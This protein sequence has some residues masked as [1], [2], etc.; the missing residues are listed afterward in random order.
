MAKYTHAYYNIIKRNISITDIRRE[1]LQNLTYSEQ[2]YRGHLFC[3]GCEIVPLAL[4][5]SNGLLYF[6]GYPNEKHRDGCL[7]SLDI[8]II[9]DVKKIDF[10]A[11][12]QADTQ[13]DAL[14]RLLSAP[15]I[16]DEKAD[17]PHDT[18]CEDG[19]QIKHRTQNQRKR[20]PQCFIED[21]SAHLKNGITL[22]EVCIY[23]GEVFCK[24]IDEKSPRDRN[25]P[26]KVLII[27]ESITG[28]EIMGL[29]MS[30][31]VWNYL[32]QNIQ[33]KLQKESRPIKIAFLGI[34]S[35]QQAEALKLPYVCYLRKS[36][37]LKI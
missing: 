36:S 23:Y 12:E 37:Y 26:I 4:V 28:K 5:H 15:P 9:S 27:K 24:V 32:G 21:L 20:L 19:R 2:K 8:R 30:Q 25:T 16:E 33:S 11:E 31:N 6:R 35:P 29:T 10:E 14:L 22:P 3:P 7:F 34:P 18:E 13:M 1:H 17:T